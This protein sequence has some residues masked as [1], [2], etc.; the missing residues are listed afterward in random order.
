MTS[1]SKC[2]TADK[3]LGSTKSYIRYGVPSETERELC[4]STTQKGLKKRGKTTS[5]TTTTGHSGLTVESPL[6]S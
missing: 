2:S 5:A 4:C 3:T 1:S 6:K